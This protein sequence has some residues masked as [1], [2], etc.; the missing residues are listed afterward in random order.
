MGDLT[1]HGMDARL[2][3]LLSSQAG[4]EGMTPEQLALKIISDHVEA[5]RTAMGREM[6]RLRESTRG[7]I[8]VDPVDIIRAD[9]DADWQQ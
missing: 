5:S 9:R 1:I 8:T 7:R 2:A 4:R 6:D 3:T